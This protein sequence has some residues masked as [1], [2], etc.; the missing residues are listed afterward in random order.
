MCF[1]VMKV[2][3]FASTLRDEKMA[4][5]VDD[6]RYPGQGRSQPEDL[7]LRFERDALPLLDELYRAAHR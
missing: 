3:F 1:G 6:S 2:Y 4:P 5:L 7:T